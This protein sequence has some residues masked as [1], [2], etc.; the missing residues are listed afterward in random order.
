MKNLLNNYI[1]YI[2]LNYMNNMDNN[3]Y[4]IDQCENRAKVWTNNYRGCIVRSIYNPKDNKIYQYSMKYN[5][6]DEYKKFFNEQK[7]KNNNFN[8]KIVNR[9][10]ELTNKF[11]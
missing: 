8:S 3:Y 7:N 9:N 11:N 4:Y 6:I 10:L 5:D 2:D 1:Y